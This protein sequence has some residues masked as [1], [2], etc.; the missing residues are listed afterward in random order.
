MLI[1]ISW[2]A[3]MVDQLIAA[4]IAGQIR[5]VDLIVNRFGFGAMRITGEGIW[6][7]PAD[8][9]GAIELLRTA[10]KLG[11]NFF[12]TAD[13]YGPEV[14]E[15]I[16]KDALFP[17]KGLVIATKGGLTRSGP[18]QWSPDC[19]PLHLR[20]ACEASLSRLKLDVIDLYQLHTVDPNVP[21]EESFKTLL[22]LQR[23]GKI[24]HI[25]LSNIEPAHFSQAMNMGHF[26][27]VQNHYN[28]FNREHEDVMRL[29]E[30]YGQIFI[31]YFPVGGN[32]GNGVKDTI[33][34]AV[35]EKHQATN[36]QIALAWI[37]NHSTC[38]LPIAG[39]SSIQH[40]KDN[41][42]AVRIDL[43]D[44]DI[45]QLDSIATNVS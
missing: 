4:D 20:Q 38:T 2:E 23:E 31:P 34:N 10:A 24:R 18:A 45:K 32:R 22:D 41:L 14:S 39:T 43:D 12:D 13:A 6:G 33:I 28:L 19:S 30:Q 15:K 7:E 25:G 26:V 44:E 5:V 16:I 11:I 21:F 35:A 37:L 27:S 8:R 42:E 9:D 40:L 29:C 1:F 17:Y 3:G 36:H